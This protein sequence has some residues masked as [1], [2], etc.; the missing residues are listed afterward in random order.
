MQP[1]AHI[2]AERL[3]AGAA[4]VARYFAEAFQELDPESGMEWRAV[5]AGVAAFTGP[6]SPL[7]AIKGVGPEIS[8]DEIEIAEDFLFRK[9]ASQVVFELAPWVNEKG[10]A[11][12]NSRGYR[13]VSEE[14]VV[15]RKTR[16]SDAPMPPAREVLRSPN[17]QMSSRLLQEAFELPQTRDTELLGLAMA[18]L[19]GAVNLVATGACGDFGAVA[20]LLPVRGMA[21]LGGD[22][23]LPRFRGQ[24]LQRA[25]INE[26]VRRAAIAGLE[27]CVAEVI[28]D[29]GSMRN[30]LRCGFEVIYSR[31]HFARGTE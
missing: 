19:P 27:Y 12:L 10:F 28:P 3:E 8:S 24:G 16:P 26:R 30:Y 25:L 18:A 9:G 1:T 14:L 31:R 2:L 15:I 21:L 7:T 22:G 17:Q 11:L 4:D 6:N 5:G 20:Q 29:G 23:T 13:Q